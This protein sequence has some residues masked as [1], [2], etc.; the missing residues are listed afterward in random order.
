MKATVVHI[1][2]NNE[3]Y[4]IVEVQRP[5]GPVISKIAGWMKLDKGATTGQE[6]ELPIGTVC[7]IQAKGSFNHLI[8]SGF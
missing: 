1:A 7:S 3:E 2:P 4:G 5:V 6:F 8:L